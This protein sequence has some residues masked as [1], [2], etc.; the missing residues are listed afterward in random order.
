MSANPWMKFYPRDWRGDQALRIVSLA[1]RGLWMECLAIMHEATPYGHLVVNGRPLG[2]DAL[3][4]M[5]GTSGDEV[6]TLMSELHE[7]GVYDMTGAGVIFSRRMVRDQERSAKGRKAVKK[8]WSQAAETKPQTGGPNRSPNS[9]PITQKPEARGQRDTRASAPPRKP[10]RFDEAWSA[11]PQGQ[12]RNC[13]KPEAL[14]AWIGQMKAGTDEGD[15]LAAVAAYARSAE[16]EYA[17][18]FDKFMRDE[19]WREHVAKHLDPAEQAEAWAA[20]VRV[21]ASSGRWPDGIGPRPGE[22][23]CQAPAEIQREHGFT[24]KPRDAGR[25]A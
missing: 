6:R 10:E 19:I 15:M 25:A 24:P 20:R 1:A 4:R 5:V 17:L 16:P 7:A 3:A 8:R 22:A 21:F 2:S 11:Y 13:G 23:G 9:P 12:G 18:R 14:R